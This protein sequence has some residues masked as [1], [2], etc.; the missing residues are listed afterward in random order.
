MLN[1]ICIMGRLTSDPELV[2]TKN[3][4]VIAKF[5][6][7]VDRDVKGKTDFIPCVAWRGTA[8]FVGKFFGKGKMIC[9]VG[10]L[11]NN[12]YEDKNGNKRSS[13]SVNVESVSFCGDKASESFTPVD[14][15]FED[16]GDEDGELPF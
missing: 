12:P 8:E 11:E 14:V 2:K 10:R 15:K 4:L 7:A 1:K 16:L 3:D 9:C 5:T 6:V 13:W